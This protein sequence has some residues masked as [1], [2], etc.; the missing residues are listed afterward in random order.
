MGLWLRSPTLHAGEIVLWRL[1]A[2]MD[3][4]GLARGGLLTV[5]SARIIFTPNRLDK[6]MG[7]RDW[8]VAS[9]EIRGCEAAD[10]VPKSVLAGG[11][12]R[13]LRIMLEDGAQELFVVR[14]AGQAAGRLSELLRLQA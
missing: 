3:Q 13:R 7:G 10:R 14:D 9:G 4:N 12:R 8:S 1:K 5:T 2:N 11:L 6:R